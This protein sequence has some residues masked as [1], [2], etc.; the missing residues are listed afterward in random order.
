MEQA[1][2]RV[3][4]NKVGDDVPVLG[5]TPA[6]ALL[7]HLLHQNNNGGK[8][9]GDKMHEKDAELEIKVDKKP[10]MTDDQPRNDVQEYRRLVG[11]Y[12]ALIN[13]N[14]VKIINMVWPDKL[15]PKLPQKFS[16]LPWAQIQ[17]DG[18]EVSAINYITGTPVQ[19]A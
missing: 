9:F 15:N 18:T 11:K 8:T 12:G 2:V 17:Y 4:L 19:K 16:E 6:E 14:G 3:R 10:A 1:T 5:V 7:L 13:K